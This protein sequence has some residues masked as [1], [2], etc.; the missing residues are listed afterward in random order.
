MIG[1]IDYG[2]GNIKSV[3]N[4]FKYIGADVE[5]ISLDDISEAEALVLPGV[6]AFRDT[7]TALEPYESE[8]KTY[9]RSGKP[10]LGICIGLQR[11]EEH[12]SELQSH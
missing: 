2:I 10:F 12:T 8:L 6:G 4:A 9:I 11:S 7:A 1:I 5:L 3:L